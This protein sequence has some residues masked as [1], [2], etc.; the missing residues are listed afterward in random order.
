MVYGSSTKLSTLITSIADSVSSDLKTLALN[1]ADSWVNSKIS[2]GGSIT[3]IP[4]L[5]ED[6]ATHFA[7][8]YLLRNLFDVSL[9]DTAMAQWEEKLANNLIDAYV[10]QSAEEDSL[11]HPYS[12]SKTPTRKELNKNNKTS[13]DY[14]DYDN[15]DDTK[16]DSER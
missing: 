6:A 5:L 16:W 15:M 4:I 7:Y 14:T 10:A 11:V 3:T 9:E 2:G 12:S 8:A 1:V 13:Y